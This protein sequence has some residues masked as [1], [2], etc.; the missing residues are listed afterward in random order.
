MVASKP[1]ERMLSQQPKARLLPRIIIKRILQRSADIICRHVATG[2]V[3]RGN[4]RIMNAVWGRKM[5]ATTRI[6]KF[7]SRHSGG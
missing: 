1:P 3:T 7:I 4:N 2:T 5:S 6:A